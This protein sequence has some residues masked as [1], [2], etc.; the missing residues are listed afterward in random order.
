MRPW[1]LVLIGTLIIIAIDFL[2]LGIVMKSFYEQIP[3]RGDV[4]LVAAILTWLF[5]SIGIVVF[6]LP[7]VS[8]WQG[9]LLRGAMFGLVV[10]AVYDLTN[11]AVLADWPLNVVFVDIAW[12][13]V[14][15]AITSTA[16]WFISGT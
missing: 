2:W 15:C 8:T 3:G 16:L 11:Y 10:Y 1:L 5:I 13:T 6:V 12:G 14:L 9:A 4:R 7:L